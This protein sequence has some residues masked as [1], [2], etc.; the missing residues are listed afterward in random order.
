M[1]DNNMALYKDHDHD[2]ELKPRLEYRGEKFNLDFKSVSYSIYHS[3]TYNFEIIGKQIYSGYDSSDS[4]ALK[5]MKDRDG[6]FDVGGRASVRTPYGLLSLHVVSDVLGEHKGQEVDLRFGA[7]FYQRLWSTS[8]EAQ[9]GLT[10]SQGVR[11]QSKDVIDHFYGVKS[12]E[13]SSTRHAYDGN[14]AL[15]PYIG[16]EPTL[17]YEDFTID[18]G[19]R[20]EWLPSEITDSPIASGNKLRVRLGLTYWFQ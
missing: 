14:S 12:S 16:L 18:G 7:P 11:W 20:Y 19:L 4:S 1:L 10:L 5:G 17:S 9:L 15:I 13:V 2:A 3:G 6:S 8:G